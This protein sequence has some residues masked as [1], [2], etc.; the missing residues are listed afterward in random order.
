MT[1]HNPIALSSGHG[2]YVR[3]A[4]GPSPWGLDERDENVKVVNR[5][6]QILNEGG[7]KAYSFHDNTSRDVNTNL[8]TIVNWHNSLKRSLDVSVHFNATAGAVG[9]EVWYVSQE[10]LAGKVSAAIAAA[11]HLKD[12]GAKYTN[13]LFV[14]NHT[15]MPCVL[16]EICFCDTKSD[17]ELYREHFEAICHAIAEALA[18]KMLG[19]APPD[20]ER[21][22]IP[23]ERP[24][25]DGGRATIGK[26]D[27]GPDVVFLQ[28]TLGVLKADGD[29]GTITDTWVRAF[30]AACGIAADGIVGPQTWDEVTD[31]E[32]GVTDGDPRLPRALADQIHA[33][34]M[35]SEIADCSW[36]D[37]GM[38]PPGYIA[39]MAQAFA[40]AMVR[41]NA[42]DQAARIMGEKE[43]DPDDDALAWY[44]E[45]FA[46]LGMSNRKAGLDTLR[47]LFVMMTGLGMRE[48]SGRYCEGRDM[49]ASN[50]Q[51]DTCEAGL[52]QTSWNIKGFS[53]AIEP[54]LDDFWVN[55]TG[56]LGTF[57]EGVTAT[58][59]NLSCYGSGDGARYQWLS[60][61]APLFHIL[62]TGV[63][64]RK[65]RAHWGPIGRREVDIRP[66]MDE[67][68]QEVQML[69]EAAGRV[70]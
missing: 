36:P 30:Q 63:G 21:P 60:R 18:G 6:A 52:D 50:V 69:V 31:L 10:A 19:E 70:V 44:E 4:A 24:P 39:G 11:G 47:H 20:G 14:L 53:S 33:I 17:C 38:P 49:S 23:P 42:G 7:V 40:Y 34:A 59:D 28:E 25:P 37:R 13:D 67:L 32:T 58:A 55:P 41:W 2:L 15:S 64:M 66:E 1:E 68:L 16:L 65:G 54:L 61:F 45:E 57:K 46:E 62:V 56:F 27:T 51:S 26:G 48:S 29:F 8:N 12:R 3:G 35:D 22:P 5:V 9:C 43:G